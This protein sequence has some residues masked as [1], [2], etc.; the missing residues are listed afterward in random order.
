M[1]ITIE[2]PDA[3]TYEIYATEDSVTFGIRSQ[4]PAFTE[5][6]CKNEPMFN[7]F[8]VL[9]EDGPYLKSETVGI[10]GANISRNP[11]WAEHVDIN[12]IIYINHLIVAL[13]SA[14]D[15]YLKTIPNNG[16]PEISTN[17]DGRP[18]STEEITT[19]LVP[20][21]LTHGDIIYDKERQQFGRVIGYEKKDDQMSVLNPLKHLMLWK[22]FSNQWNTRFVPCVK[23]K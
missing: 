1:K 21:K 14:A 22:D 15:M 17:C 16:M 6:I 5:W 4:N 13:N 11:V 9:S 10:Q 8:T 12:P 19:N 23:Q 18:F 2:I 3:I 20:F 7:G